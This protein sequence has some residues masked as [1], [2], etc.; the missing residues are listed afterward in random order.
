MASG[1]FLSMTSLWLAAFGGRE[2]IIDKS[3]AASPKLAA[4][5]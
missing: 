1:S 4:V 3:D 2:A 5:G